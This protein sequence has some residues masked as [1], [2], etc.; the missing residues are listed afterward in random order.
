MFWYAMGAVKIFQRRIEQKKEHCLKNTHIY[1]LIWG[2]YWYLY[3]HHFILSLHSTKSGNG[4][5]QPISSWQFH[6]LF[7]MRLLQQKVF[8][9][10]MNNI[11]VVCVY[12]TCRW[13]RYCSLFV[14]HMHAYILFTYGTSITYRLLS[15]QIGWVIPWPQ[16]YWY[17]Q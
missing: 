8:G 10:S 15:L 17:W 3:W 13:K 14:F 2:V 16:Y 1:L 11:S 5:F 7:G 12:I 4:T 9:V 6:S